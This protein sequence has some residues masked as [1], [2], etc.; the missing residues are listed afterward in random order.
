MKKLVLFYSIV[1]CVCLLTISIFFL[2]SSGYSKHFDTKEAIGSAM[3]GEFPIYKLS[4]AADKYAILKVNQNINPEQFQGSSYAALLIDNT[5]NKVLVAHNALKRIYP[6]STTKLMTAIVVCDAVEKGK[7]SYDDEVY[8][9]HYINLSNPDAV[10]SMLT[11]DETITVRNLLF[12]MLMESYNDYAIILAEYVGGSNE[13]F[14]KLMNEKAAEIGATGTHFVNPHGLHH[15][16]HYTT[17]YDMYLIINEAAKYDIIREIDKY[18]SFTYTYLDSDG[19]E[20]EDNITPTNQFLAGNYT[21]PSNITIKEWKTGT[22]AR[23]GSVLTMI[24]DIDGKEYTM[25]IA[26]S[27]GPEDLYQKYTVMFNLTKEN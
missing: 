12:G 8:L 6:A 24:A 18:D 7:I 10:A 13:G 27:I 17:A 5:D 4:G 21:L 3:T 15:D 22:T 14:A 1:V 19:V 16:D 26:D 23:A 9:D 20:Q 2:K 11:I 25:F